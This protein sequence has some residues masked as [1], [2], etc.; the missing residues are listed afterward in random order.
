MAAADAA[1]KAKAYDQ[2]ALTLVA[3]QQQ[4]GLTDQQAQAVH[5]RMVQLQGALASALANGD[6]K[7]QAAAA[8]LR[9]SAMH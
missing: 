9:Q 4:K 5:T 8:I 7:A 3:L 2:A 6:A 1:L